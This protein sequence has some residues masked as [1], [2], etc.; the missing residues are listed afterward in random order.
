MIALHEPDAPLD[1]AAGILRLTVGRDEI[2][3]LD[4]PIIDIGGIQVPVPEGA[5]LQAVPQAEAFMA[6]R[7]VDAVTRART[8]AD[9]FAGI[10]TLTFPIADRARVS[11]Y[12]SDADGLAALAYAARHSSGL[13][14][15]TVRRRDL[16]REPLSRG[17]LNAFDAV[18]FDPPRAG[19]AA[20]AKALARSRVGVVVAVSCNPATLARD[21]RTLS[22]GGYQL[23]ALD[24]V[25][26]FLYSAHLEAVAVFK[27]RK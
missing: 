8:V 26:Q 12:D 16:F 5:F 9:L 22:G 4:Q 13:K 19:A 11:A 2:F 1:Q 25:D 14:P 7:V 3:Q 6:S 17:E 20:Q 18:I 15:V 21:A 27:R 23:V 24:L 10:G